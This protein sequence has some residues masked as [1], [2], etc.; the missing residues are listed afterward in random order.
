MKKRFTE[1]HIVALN[2]LGYAVILTDPR[3][4]T[5]TVG[6]ITANYSQAFVLFLALWAYCGVIYLLLRRAKPLGILLASLPILA[7]AVMGTWYAMFGQ[8]APIAAFI[9]PSLSAV[10]IHWFLYT[11]LDAMAK[12]ESLDDTIPPPLDKP[13][14]TGT[15]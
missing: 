4:T 7:Y 11:R 6:F 2:L 8:N 12:G 1:R 13:H 9:L 3:V 14:D 5:G 15:D 10:N